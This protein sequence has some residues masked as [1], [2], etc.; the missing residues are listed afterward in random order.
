MGA[1]MRI[2]NRNIDTSTLNA[3]TTHVGNKEL[4]V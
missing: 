1:L 3:I 2:M 4:I